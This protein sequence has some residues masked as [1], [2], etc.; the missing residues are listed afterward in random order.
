MTETISE[1]CEARAFLFLRQSRENTDLMHKNK[2]A[3]L[4]V[5]HK[6]GSKNSN[7]EI[8]LQNS[9]DNLKL[10]CYDADVPK[11]T[12]CTGGNKNRRGLPPLPERRDALEK[13]TAERVLAELA[14]IAFADLGAE[15]A[16]PVKVGDKLR[17]LELIYKYLGL[18]DGAVAEEPVVIVDEAP[19]EQEVTP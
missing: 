11:R 19:T 17:A 8:M 1:T 15:P 18:G 9:V 10:L 14:E 3:V 12:C 5:L 2:S 4:E 7:S 6:Y 13:I 16:P